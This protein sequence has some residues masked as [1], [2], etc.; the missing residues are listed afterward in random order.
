MAKKKHPC[1]FNV[2]GKCCFFDSIGS[3]TAQECNDCYKWLEEQKKER[4]IK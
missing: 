4:G 1:Y 2:D 3:P